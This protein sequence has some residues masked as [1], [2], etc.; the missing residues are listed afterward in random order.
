MRRHGWELPYHPLQITSVA[1][2]LALGFAFY[3][4]FVPFLDYRMFEICGLATYSL[5][6]MVVYT[7]YIWCAAIDPADIQVPKSRMH[8]PSGTHLDNCTKVALEPKAECQALFRSYS[9]QSLPYIDCCLGHTCAQTLHVIDALTRGEMYFCT[10]CNIETSTSTKH[11]QICDKC[12]D[13]F[14]HHCQW[15]NN[16]IG[17]RNYKKFIFLLMAA[18][19]MFTLQSLFGLWIVVHQTLKERHYKYIIASKLG[20]SF[21]SLGY[22]LVVGST[23]YDYAVAKSEKKGETEEACH[24][25]PK[26]GSYSER[27]WQQHREHGWFDS[28]L[29][30]DSSGS[31]QMKEVGGSLRL[32]SQRFSS[33]KTSVKI[34]PW[35]VSLSNEEGDAHTVSTSMLGLS[36]GQ[37]GVPMSDPGSSFDHRPFSGNSLVSA[38]NGSGNESQGCSETQSN[39]LDQLIFCEWQNGKL[40][41]DPFERLDSSGADS[42]CL[43]EPVVHG[44]TLIPLQREARDVFRSSHSFCGSVTPASLPR[45]EQKFSHQEAENQETNESLSMSIIR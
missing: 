29:Q 3:I 42:G 44:N 40:P 34:N 24:A 31:K 39:R 13:G 41:F 5:T 1:G 2:S 21:S 45:S 23:T 20:R 26:E 18:S 36:T 25:K 37:I 32:L 14:D 12:I 19:F 43:T 33:R 38:V 11:C 16:C 17:K 9:F 35:D 22:L 7:L 15:L 28:E 4:F 10:V 6:V 8:F 30:R 27:S